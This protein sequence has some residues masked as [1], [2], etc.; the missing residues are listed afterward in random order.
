MKIFIFLCLFLSTLCISTFKI[1]NNIA[2]NTKYPVYQYEGSR[3]I[4][5]GTDIYLRMKILGND[6][7]QISLETYSYYIHTFG[8]SVSFFDYYPSDDEIILSKYYG[9]E[10][11]YEETEIIDGGISTYAYPFDTPEDKKYLGIHINVYNT[12]GYLDLTVI[13]SRDTAVST[14]SSQIELTWLLKFLHIFYL[15]LIILT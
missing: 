1:I 5:A 7:M 3:F 2:F 10:I 13:E 11:A 8:V 15:L 12:L 6:K 4:S 14:E 9:K